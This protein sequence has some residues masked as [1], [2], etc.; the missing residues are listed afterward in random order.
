MF[1]AYDRLGRESP[2]ALATVVQFSVII[3]GLLAPPPITEKHG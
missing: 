1:F 2:T 3:E